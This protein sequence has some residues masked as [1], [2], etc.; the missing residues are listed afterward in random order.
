MIQNV[1]FD[2]RG[3]I[4]A[5]LQDA[6]TSD[7]IGLYQMNNE[8]LVRTLSTGRAVFLDEAGGGFV[9]GRFRLVDVRL[10]AEGGAL[11]VLVETADQNGGPDGGPD[12]GPNGGDDGTSLLREIN[13]GAPA[14]VSLVDVGSL[15]FGI[16]INKLYALIIDR[17]EKRPEGSYTSYLFNSGL[18]K[19]LKKIAEESGEVIIAAKNKSPVEIISELSDLFYH[20]L[21]LM[22]E[23]GVSLAEVQAELARRAGAPGS[24]GREGAEPSPNHS[25]S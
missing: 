25:H 1:K 16:A 10:I 9:G 14:E 4:P 15:D 18:D 24:H 2:E 23:R 11:S 7:V 8:C 17:K 3:L 21:V 5:I 22:V 12:G 6:S 13:R 19:I 20:L